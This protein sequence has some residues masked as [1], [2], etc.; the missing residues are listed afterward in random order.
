MGDPGTRDDEALSRSIERA[1]DHHR[2]DRVGEAIQ[3]YRQ[4][5]ELNPSLPEMHNN[6]G[7]LLKGQ[8]LWEEARAAFERA[9]QAKPDCADAWFNLGN[10]CRTRSESAEAIDCYKLT[11]LL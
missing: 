9:L 10:L 11:L 8:G 5:L 2:A 1:L 6:L 7:T 3:S 4:V